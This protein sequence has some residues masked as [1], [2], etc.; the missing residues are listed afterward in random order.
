[1]SAFDFSGLNNK[2]SCVPIKNPDPETGCRV[3]SD[4]AK[5]DYEQCRQTFYLKQQNEIIKQN[6]QTVTSN[7]DQKIK[8]LESL[9]AN[10]QKITDQQNQQ[11][12]QLTQ[13]SEQ[14]AH[15]IENLNLINVI[16]ITGL[17]VIACAFLV[18]KFMERKSTSK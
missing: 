9:N 7:N 13:S 18:T 3:C 10:L 15:K 6:L 1:M 14:A 11:I 4:N 2:Y 16:L 8:D 5:N 12:T 17:V